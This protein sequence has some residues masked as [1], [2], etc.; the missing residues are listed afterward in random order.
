MLIIHTK[1]EYYYIG[2][3]TYSQ[4]DG[5][6]VQKLGKN[7]N[8][9]FA[10]SQTDGH[11]GAKIKTRLRQSP[12]TWLNNLI[13]LSHLRKAFYFPQSCPRYCFDSCSAQNKLVHIHSIRKFSDKGKFQP[14]SFLF[15]SS[16]YVN[17][18]TDFQILLWI[19]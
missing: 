1:H 12:S 19:V 2:E 11:T 14:S 18:R 15:A 13:T 7:S 4:G 17:L 16:E 9:I 3:W 8:L 10:D 5:L 6:L